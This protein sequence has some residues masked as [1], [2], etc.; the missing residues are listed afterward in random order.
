MKI[1][2][3][4]AWPYANGSLHIGHISSLL[5]GDV[6]ARYHRLTGN[7][8]CYV[9]GSDCHGTPLTIRAK[10]ENKQPE[11]ICEKYHSEFV[12]AF[13]Y[14]NFS[15][16]YYGKTT[17]QSHK[18][19][20]TDFHSSLYKSKFVYEKEEE[21]AYCPSCRK[22]LPDRL[23]IGKCPNCFADSRG[24]Q[25]EK[26]GHIIEST[27]LLEPVC[28][29]CSSKPEFVLTKNLYIAISKLQHEI[30]K[31]LET[32]NKSWKSNAIAFT[33]RYLNEGLRD[34]ALTRDLDW[35]IDVPKKGYE[36]KKIYI[37]A[38]NVLGYLSACLNLCEN[39]GLEFESFW[40]NNETKH[41]YT[42][43]KDNIP[44]HTIILPALLIASGENYNL[45]NYIVSS[46]YLTL[47]GRKISTSQNWAIWI[48]DLIG[49]YNS[50]AI[51]Y[52]LLSCGP[53]KRDSDF[54]WQ[55]FLY[56]NNSELL[57]A[58]GNF[59]N[60]TL[61]FIKKSFSSTV[62]IGSIK[63]SIQLKIRELYINT[64]DDITKGEI[65]NSLKRI[66]TFVRDAN[67]Y[68]DDEK[69][70]ITLK[71]DISKCQNTLYNCVYIIINVAI[72]LEPYLPKSSNK[73]IEWFDLERKWQEQ[74]LKAGFQIPEFNILFERLDKKIVND[75]LSRL[76]NKSKKRDT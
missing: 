5:P 39:T 20:V 47:E 40:K 14:L 72:L 35:G 67:K 18:D 22:H 11:E 17:S 54:S 26:C 34:R 23:L 66:F 48:K 58:Y 36:N 56:C 59:I 62:P 28:S 3:G 60:R 68:F 61:A 27:E 55:E 45:P 65:K 41:Y 69:P 73:I 16:D 74:T 10:S 70:W 71:T 7:D 42:H 2:I 15:Y 64:G 43:G 24:D 12:D 1:L 9:S 6:I 50:D 38:E 13:D 75:E 31:L 30:T 57:G 53:E 4:G 49:K 21:Q 32:N 8:V 63:G 76:S 33:K 46:E 51:R 52:Y 44:F 29:Q 25:C 37:W 19:F